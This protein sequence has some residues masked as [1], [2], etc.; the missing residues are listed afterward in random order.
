MFLLHLDAAEAGVA[1]WS[2]AGR[3]LDRLGTLRSGGVRRA[4]QQPAGDDPGSPFFQD[5]LLEPLGLV[6]GDAELTHTPGQVLAGSHL[7]WTAV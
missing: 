3:R 2:N 7:R 5:Q 1:R 4:P 6:G